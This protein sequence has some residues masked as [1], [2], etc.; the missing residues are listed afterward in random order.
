MTLATGIDESPC[1]E[2]LSL[3][4]CEFGAAWMDDSTFW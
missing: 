4:R 3:D 1:V 2:Q